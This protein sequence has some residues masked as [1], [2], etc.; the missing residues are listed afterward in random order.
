[1]QKIEE[2]AKTTTKNGKVT[3][4]HEMFFNSVTNMPGQTCE[5]SLQ[6]QNTWRHGIFAADRTT[7]GQIANGKD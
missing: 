6:W 2:Q 7:V 3:T 5:F 4:T 1:M